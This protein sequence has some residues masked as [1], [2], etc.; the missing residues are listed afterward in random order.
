M[1]ESTASKKIEDLVKEWVTASVNLDNARRKVA[2]SQEWLGEK[3]WE[4][5][6]AL[7]PEDAK[8]NETFAVWIRVENIGIPGKERLLQIWKDE[9]EKPHAQWRA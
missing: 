5:A 8:V 7:L 6:D 9:N 1:P 2:D 4:L 3:L